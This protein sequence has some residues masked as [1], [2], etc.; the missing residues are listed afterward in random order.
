MV[1]AAL[2]LNRLFLAP[3]ADGV[4]LINTAWS[5]LAFA[6]RRYAALTILHFCARQ[7]RGVTFVGVSMSV[8]LAIS[9]LAPSLMIDSWLSATIFLALRHHLIPQ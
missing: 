8:G 5:H 2:K 7:K 6:R 4:T 1:V 3:Y 9:F